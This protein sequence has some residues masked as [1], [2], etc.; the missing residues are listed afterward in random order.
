[1]PFDPRDGGAAV[2]VDRGGRRLPF[3]ADYVGLTLTPKETE[4]VVVALDAKNPKRDAIEIKS[5]TPAVTP[6]AI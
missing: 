3:A 2:L 4:K 5:A 6:S 1:V